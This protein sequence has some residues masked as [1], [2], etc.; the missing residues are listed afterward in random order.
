MKIEINNR[1]KLARVNNIQL[2]KLVLYLMDKVHKLDPASWDEISIVIT[3]DAGIKAVNQKYLNKNH[4]TDV[5]SFRYAPAPG[6]SDLP[7]GEVIV[8]LQRVL[9]LARKRK[10]LEPCR[11]LALYIAHGCD[12]LADQTDYDTV[13]RN[14]MRRRE[15]QWLAG[16]P[17][18]QIMKTVFCATI[19]FI[20][21]FS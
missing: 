7:S 20:I 16:A 11:E 1:Q 21:N 5:I 19:F 8:N 9:E 4:V 10:N 2:K 6:I 3:D 18:G 14:R 17:W 15:L 13:S 12:H